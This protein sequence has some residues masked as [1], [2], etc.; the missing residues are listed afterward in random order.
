M[1]GHDPRPTPL[2]NRCAPDGSLH[3]VAARGLLMG[4]RGGRLHRPDR[5][6][7][8]ARWRSRAWI[9]CVLDFHSRHRDVWGDGYTEI[10]FLDEATALAAGHRPCFEC[11]RADAHA[12]AAAWA[13]AVGLATPPRA[14]EMDRILHAERLGPPD[15]VRFADLP[16][17][18]IFTADG[19]FLLRIATG[20]RRWSFAGY[21]PA[22][23]YAAGETVAAITPAHTRAA[24]AAGYR[25]QIHPSAVS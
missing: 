7:G 5:T 12:F 4:N 25:P 20:A 21:G 14:A 8:A 9:A 15:P 13:R 24:L 22:R 19:D 23:T 18:A 10:F 17:G 3:A 11:R 6:L 16:E 1:A 2:E